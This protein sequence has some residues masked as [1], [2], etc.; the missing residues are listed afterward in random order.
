VDLQ[1]HMTFEN[2]YVLAQRTGLGW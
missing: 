1:K 2:E